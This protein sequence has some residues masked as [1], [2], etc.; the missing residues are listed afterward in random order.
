MAVPKPTKA[1]PRS[2]RARLR[3]WA[4][5]VVIGV[6]CA[7]DAQAQ[8]RGV[9]VSG[10]VFDSLSQRWL[11]GA[12]V[13]LVQRDVRGK[14]R[15]VTT[16]GSGA[17]RFDALST[18][19]YLLGFFHPLLDSLH[20]RPPWYEVAI[21]QSGEVTVPLTVPS[22]TTLRRAMCGKSAVADSQ[23]VLLTT[24]RSAGGGRPLAGSGVQARWLEFV[25]DDSG[26]QRTLPTIQGVT[27]DS[28]SLIMCGLPLA[29][30]VAVRAWLGADSSGFVEVEVP[31]SGIVRRDLLIG[32]STIDS[33]VVA[34]VDSDYVS[35][36]VR[37]GEGS[38]AGSVRDATGLPLAGAR[39]SL[40][41]T[42][43]EAR[44]DAMG[45]FRLT[46]LPTGTFTV[47]ARA[48]GYVPERQAV[49]IREGSGSALSMR[50]ESFR[51]YLDTV[52][53]TASRLYASRE[54]R[55]FEERRRRYYGHFFDDEYLERRRPM[56]V[57]DVMRM[58]P[59]ARIV[60][61]SFGNTIVLR[62]MGVQTWCLPTVFL[63]GM[64]MLGSEGS[65]DMFVNV[66][67]VRAI[68][69]YPRRLGVPSEFQGQRCG[70]ILIWTGP[71]RATQELNRR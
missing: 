63:D 34:G 43:A 16:E 54:I 69:V 33:V 7:Q 68:E 35:V 66:E 30:R 71:R 42:A 48:I 50:L 15:T 57:S 52:K 64:R 10:T 27:G 67:E 3:L 32:S 41:G 36:E 22:S 29:A 1:Q 60:P 58:V 14:A 24:V 11:A 70:S 19:V 53:V 20:I 5:C 61:G 51:A 17:F 40:W 6:A 38:I 31:A 62:D 9:R 37:R 21:R 18:G 13:Q 45:A 25:L 59:G 23:G 4:Y 56:Y 12:V 8:S 2:S 26:V 47:E 49:D 55:E 44:S 28:G 46:G 65:V 39:V